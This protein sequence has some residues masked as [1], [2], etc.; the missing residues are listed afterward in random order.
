MGDRWRSQSQFSVASRVFRHER[1]GLS[2]NPQDAE[3]KTSS[4]RSLLLPVGF[5]NFV[6]GHPTG[7]LK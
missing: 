6:E 3:Q 7:P 4:T 1:G 5:L 2:T